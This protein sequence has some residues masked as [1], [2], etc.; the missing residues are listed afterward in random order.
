M[1]NI[2]KDVIEEKPKAKKNDICICWDNSTPENK[3]PMICKGNE[4]FVNSIMDI[5]N[6]NLSVKYDNYNI[7]GKYEE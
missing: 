3:T 4:E 6:H 2:E 1:E 5:E 7:V